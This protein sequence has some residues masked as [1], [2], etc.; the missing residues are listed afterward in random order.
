MKN[1]LFLCFF[2]LS[3][4]SFG[5]DVV[6]NKKKTEPNSNVKYEQVSNIKRIEKRVVKP[7]SSSPQKEEKIK[8]N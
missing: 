3:F 1:S 5:Q 7:Q 6:K 4:L 2:V 8:K